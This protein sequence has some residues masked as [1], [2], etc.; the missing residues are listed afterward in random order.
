M[1]GGSRPG[2][3]KVWR[4]SSVK[5]VPLLSA[6]WSSRSYPERVVR[7]TSVSADGPVAA[8]TGVFSHETDHL[9]RGAEISILLLARKSLVIVKTPRIRLQ[10]WIFLP[11]SEER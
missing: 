5:A 7:I 11:R 1:R 9:P 2:R 10:C 3:G 8:G 6:G 4:S